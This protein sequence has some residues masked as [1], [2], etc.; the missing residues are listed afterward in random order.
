[1]STADREWEQP[2]QGHQAPPIA[3]YDVWVLMEDG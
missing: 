3:Q 1:M 2:P